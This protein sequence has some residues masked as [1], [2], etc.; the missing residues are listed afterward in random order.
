MNVKTQKN[1][2]PDHLREP[3][4]SP[5]RFYVTTPWV[6]NFETIGTATGTHE[7]RETEPLLQ[8]AV[9]SGAPYRWKSSLEVSIIIVINQCLSGLNDVTLKLSGV[10]HYL[11][12][13]IKVLLNWTLKAGHPILLFKKIPDVAFAWRLN[14]SE[15]IIHD[16]LRYCFVTD[17]SACSQ[18]RV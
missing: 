6:D 4:H 5:N 14:T 16:G 13:S 17:P 11:L 15:K 3:S 2:P 18:S 7:Q 12:E 9:R 10:Y 1:A 8:G